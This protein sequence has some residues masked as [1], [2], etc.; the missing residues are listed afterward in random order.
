MERHGPA[1]RFPLIPRPRPPCP[2]LGTR[3]RELRELTRPPGAADHHAALA[4]AGEACNKAA[5][6]ASDCGIPGLAREL[7]W[8]QYAIFEA[9]RPL[10]AGA[11]RLALQPVLNIPRQLIR[12]GDGAA[13]CQILG[14]LY[15]AAREQRDT[16]IDGHRVSLSGLTREP[17]DQ[18]DVCTRLWAALLADG[19]RALVAEGR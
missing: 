12:E 4:R 17:G 6:I 1:R 11:A 18:Q 9:A 3:I 15:Q 13:A 8:R 2:D 14:Q 19:T 10:P 5:L 16:E 7:C